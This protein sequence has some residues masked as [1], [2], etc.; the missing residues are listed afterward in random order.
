MMEEIVRRLIIFIELFKIACLDRV[1]SVEHLP[2]IYSG[3]EE[4]NV[5]II[6]YIKYNQTTMSHIKT[7][8]VRAKDSDNFILVYFAK[9]FTV[10]NLVDRGEKLINISQLADNYSQEHIAAMLALH[11]FTGAYCISA[12][13]GKGKVRPMKLLSHN[14]K[15]I[16]IFAAVGFPWTLDDDH[17]VNDIEEFTCRLYVVGP[18]VKQVDMAREIKVKNICGSNVDLLPLHC[19]FHVSATQTRSRP[20]HKES[21]F[22]SV[23]LAHGSRSFSR[24]TVAIDHGHHV[25]EAGKLEPHWFERDIIPMVLVDILVAN[26]NDEEITDEIHTVDDYDEQENGEYDDN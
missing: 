2:E 16:H 10:D 1:T 19:S 23:Y 24:N 8:R 13:K 26:G 6:I 11:V 17:F 18:R 3:H 5:R 9:T 25:T 20:A 14:S 12:F 15:F 22:P 4:T 7:T 21:Q